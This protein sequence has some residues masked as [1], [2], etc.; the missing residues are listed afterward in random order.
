MITKGYTLFFLLVFILSLIIVRPTYAYL[1]AGT[2][3]MLL[4][5]I[6]GGFAGLLVIIKI[7]W[8]NLMALF[9]SRDED[10]KDQ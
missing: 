2:G 9:K 3:S 5:L 1:D 7:Y 6:L 10:E 4:Q 8:R